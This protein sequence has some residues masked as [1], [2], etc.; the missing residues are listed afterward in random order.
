[1]FNPGKVGAYRL[2]GYENRVMA[3]ADFANDLKDAGEVGAGHHVT[4][5][6]ELIPPGRVR[7]VL[8]QQGPLKYQTPAQTRPSN[9]S[10]TVSVRER[11]PG[12]EPSRLFEVPAVDEGLDFSRSSP[13]FKFASAV[14]GFG[15]LLR[16]S[17]YKGSLTFGG[18]LEIAASALDDDPSGYRKEFVGL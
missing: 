10:L 15:M 1:E 5:L 3:N 6:Y 4:A 16:N 7:T 2:I 12:E 11:R 14:A 17:P 8:T 9:E 13:D 18:V